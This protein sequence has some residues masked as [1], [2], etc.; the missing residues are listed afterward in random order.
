MKKI[1]CETM[2]WYGVLAILGAYFLNSFGIITV[3]DPLYQI[4]NFTGALGII[5]DSLREKNYQPMLLNI[6]WAAIAI[7]ALT[8]IFI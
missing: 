2:G 1:I 4:L 8:K 6:F 7:I 3:S 5:M